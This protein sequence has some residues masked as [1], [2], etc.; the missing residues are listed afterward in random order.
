MVE[1]QGQVKVTPHQVFFEITSAQPRAFYIPDLGGK[2]EFQRWREMVGTV[3]LVSLNYTWKLPK[4]RRP[5]QFIIVVPK[6]S[7]LA[8]MNHQSDKME[9]ALC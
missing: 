7:S 9:N 6:F 1:G 4:K 3:G 2:L 5:K 8:L